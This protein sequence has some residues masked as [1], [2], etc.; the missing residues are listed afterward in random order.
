[1]EEKINASGSFSMAGETS[2]Y[3]HQKSGKIEC[4]FI[5]VLLLRREFRELEMAVIQ[6][7]LHLSWRIFLDVKTD[8]LCFN[9]VKVI[10]SY[11]P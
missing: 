4:A 7:W 2:L 11:L 3:H 1:M 6:A 5:V 10:K 8:R 9:D